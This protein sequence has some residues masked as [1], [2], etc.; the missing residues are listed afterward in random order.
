[1]KEANEINKSLLA[2]GGVIRKLSE[3]DGTVIDFRSSKLTHVMKD[4]LGGTAKTLMFVNLSPS[5][6][7]VVETKGSLDFASNTKNITNAA[8]KNTDDAEKTELKNEIKRLMMLKD[9]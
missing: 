7:N 6:D 8:E 5:A 9:T 2:L 4:S 1:L 3:P